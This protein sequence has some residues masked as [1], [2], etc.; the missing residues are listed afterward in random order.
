MYRVKNASYV[1]SNSYHCAIF[2]VLF[3]KKF[4][5]FDRGRTSIKTA[6]FLKQVGLEDRIYAE[7]KDVLDEA[8]DFQSAKQVVE[9]MKKDSM[10][11]LERV[12]SDL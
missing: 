3:E 7:Q 8:I 9:S 10:A 5:V 12:L 6:S 1:L 4:L 11:Y 2:S